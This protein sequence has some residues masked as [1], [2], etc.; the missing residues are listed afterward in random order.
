[1]CY[2]IPC[3]IEHAGDP[4]LYGSYAVGTA[5]STIYLLYLVSTILQKVLSG[6]APLGPRFQM[7][8]VRTLYADTQWTRSNPS[9]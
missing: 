9:V 5:D 4:Q 2:D 6:I 1:M 7:L 3:I 8:F